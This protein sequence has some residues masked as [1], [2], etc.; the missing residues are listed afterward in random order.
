[1]IKSKYPYRVHGVATFSYREDNGILSIKRRQ[2]SA[3]KISLM[4]VMFLSR[5]KIR[6][7][8]DL[9]EARG[10]PRCHR[11]TIV[12][13]I[14]AVKQGRADIHNDLGIRL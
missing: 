7:M 14:V 9:V 2:Y 6:A 10:L 5:L 11:N 13:F 8:E 1:V 3:I 12:A 4:D